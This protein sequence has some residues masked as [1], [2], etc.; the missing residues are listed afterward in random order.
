MELLYRLLLF[1]AIW[2]GDVHQGFAPRY[3]KNVM[4]RVARARDLPIV[5]C[6]VSS[7]RYPIGTWVYVYGFNTD[8]LLRCRVTDVSHTHDRARHLRTKRE[9]E[10]GFEAARKLCGEAAMR[11]R[12]EACP[13]LVVRLNGQS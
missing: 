11:A 2:G 5:G 12:P 13:V 4:E 8:T 10:L 6:M 7:P 9:V 1:V 3:A